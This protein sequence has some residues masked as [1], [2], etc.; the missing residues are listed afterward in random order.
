M[1]IISYILNIFFFFNS[2][3]SGY[4]YCLETFNF[5]DL[6]LPITSKLE[7]VIKNISNTIPVKKLK[8]G[9]E[10]FRV[11]PESDWIFSKY[12]PDLKEG[13]DKRY[14][15]IPDLRNVAL[16]IGRLRPVAIY[17][18]IRYLGQVFISDFSL[19]SYTGEGV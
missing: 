8:S 17:T 16:S 19:D 5:E 1:N 3:T 18:S 4:K 9:L 13:E 12:L 7:A 6:R 11:T 14:M 15:T 2:A 10:F